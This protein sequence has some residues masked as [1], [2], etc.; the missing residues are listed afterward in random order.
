MMADNEVLESSPEFALYKAHLHSELHIRRTLDQSFYRTIDT[1]ARDIDQ[2]VYRYEQEL[3][4]SK[5]QEEDSRDDVKVLMVDQL[6]MW[7]LGDDL[8]VT[9]FPQRWRQPPKDPLNV[10]E[11]I[12]EEINS[13]TTESVDNVYDLAILIA[14]RCFGTFDQSDVRSDGSRFLDMFESSIGKAMDDETHF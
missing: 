5:H 12:M 14:G 1:D 9:S 6:W 11:G 8:V 3:S 7:I 10:L 2:V 4:K 13:A